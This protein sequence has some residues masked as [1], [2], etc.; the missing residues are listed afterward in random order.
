M[1]P[2][3]QDRSQKFLEWNR[4][5]WERKNQDCYQKAGQN[6][7]PWY[8]TGLDQDIDLCLIKYAVPLGKSVCDLGTCSGSQA[9]GLA[10]RGYEVVGTDV[11]Q[12]ALDQATTAASKYRGLNLQFLLDDVLDSRLPTD[13]FDV[14]FDRGCFHSLFGFVDTQLYAASIVRLLKPN[15]LLVI[16]MMN[17]AE[18]RFQKTD[19]VNGQTRL[20]PYHFR[21]DEL[22]GLFSPPL[23][24]L[25][26]CETVFQ[27]SVVRPDPVAWLMVLRN[28]KAKDTAVTE[29]ATSD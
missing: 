29:S 19:T 1:K 10:I 12:T 6:R 2:S 4:A 3:S 24:S 23:T 11:S 7:F 9:I 22:D 16:K 5:K 15:G 13:R 25:E 20:M 21:R 28:D 8:F 27:S 17:A 18:R 26:V 14:I